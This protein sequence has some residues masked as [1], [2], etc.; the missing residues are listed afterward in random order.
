MARGTGKGAGGGS[1]KLG[2][3]VV[4]SSGGD[5]PGRVVLRGEARRR[6]NPGPSEE[7]V[8]RMDALDRACADGMHRM[9]SILVD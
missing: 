4:G 2:V 7:A 1:R 9:R 3:V 8:R 5:V 6:L